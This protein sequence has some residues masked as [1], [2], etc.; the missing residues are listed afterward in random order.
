M[1]C[2]CFPFFVCVDAHFGKSH[3]IWIGVTNVMMDFCLPSSPFP[4]HNIY[5]LAF[6]YI[7]AAIF[8]PGS[9]QGNGGE[10][11]IMKC[12]HYVTSGKIRANNGNVKTRQRVRFCR[13][14]CTCTQFPKS[15]FI[16]IHAVT[17]IHFFW[18]FPGEITTR[19]S[20]FLCA[21]NIQVHNKFKLQLK[22]KRTRRK[23][24]TRVKTNRKT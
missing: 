16:H 13:W 23:L 1:C 2:V 10:M 14:I 24:R 7:A 19:F 22:M 9:A 3:V 4:F 20:L 11:Q 15:V 17:C 21:A 6:Y 8:F 5:A 18:L 12:M